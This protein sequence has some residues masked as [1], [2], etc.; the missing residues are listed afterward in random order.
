M[1]IYNW[2]GSRN[3]L[4]DENMQIE[5][6]KYKEDNEITI[7][8]WCDQI[9]CDRSQKKIDSNSELFFINYRGYHYTSLDSFWNIVKEDC[10]RAT[11]VRFSNDDLEYREGDKIIRELLHERRVSDY[12]NKQQYFMISFCDNNNLLSQWREYGN[13]VSIGMDFSRYS[14]FSVVKNGKDNNEFC[15]PKKEIS[16]FAQAGCCEKEEFYKPTFSMPI[17]V[18]YTNKSKTG[19]VENAEKEN[20]TEEGDCIRKE[21][22]YSLPREYF[23]YNEQG[24]KTCNYEFKAIGEA[25]LEN[26]TDARANAISQILHIIPYIKSGEFYEEREE[27]LLFSIDEEKEKELELIEFIQSNRVNKPYI[28]IK[29]GDISEKKEHCKYI[30]ISG[31][32]EKL[33]YFI[34]GLDEKLK[35][36]FINEEKIEINIKDGEEP[37]IFIS[38]GINQRRI[39]NFVE[40]YCARYS[41]NFEKIKSC[42]FEIQSIDNELVQNKEWENGLDEINGRLGRY[43]EEIGDSDIK[44]LVNQAKL[45]GIAFDNW[46]KNIDIINNSYGQFGVKKGRLVDLKSKKILKIWCDGH[47]PIRKITV[48]PTNNKEMIAENIKTYCKTKY[49]LKYVEVDYSPIPYREKREYKG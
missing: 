30:D 21:D 38:N 43:A 47:W 25:F 20:T 16:E 8:D 6:M 35:S 7:K 31:M 15:S 48:G 40:D 23:C 4:G 11:H 26:D 41:F 27:R 34:S 44:D 19:E 46:C 36:A 3:S 37:S 24:E 39:F 18:L 49:W 13:G 32:L 29:Y 28:S 2:S 22:H 14:I 12:R 10:F 1:K 45:N 9:Q 42:V 33:P 5:Y 17:N